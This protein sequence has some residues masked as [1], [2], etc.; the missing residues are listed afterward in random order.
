[1][2]ALCFDCIKD[3]SLHWYPKTDFFGNE[4]KVTEQ[5][6]IDK[7]RELSLEIGICDRCNK[8]VN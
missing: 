7:L 8:K 1:M 2:M 3:T 4:Y 6:K 5:E